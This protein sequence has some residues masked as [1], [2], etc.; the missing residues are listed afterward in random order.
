MPAAATDGIAALLS[1]IRS[2]R[3]LLEALA[4]D[5][6]RA[7]DLRGLT[8]RVRLLSATLEALLGNMAQG[9]AELVHPP[10]GADGLV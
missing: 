10:A 4:H 2:P 1:F 3:D 6:Q 7:A 9:G 5:E 8:K